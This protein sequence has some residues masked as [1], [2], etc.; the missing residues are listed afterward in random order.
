MSPI[1]I[2]LYVCL[3]SNPDA[4]EEKVIPISDVGSISACYFWAQPHIA[5]WSETHPKYKIMKW[6]C[7]NPAADGEPI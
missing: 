2:L 1:N 4:C 7:A 6:T 3:L 5:A